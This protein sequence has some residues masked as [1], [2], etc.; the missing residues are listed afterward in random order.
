MKRIM[1][2]K[3]KDTSNFLDKIPAVR[4]GLSWETDDGQI[5][6]IQE[7]KG[8]YNRIAQ[9]IFHTPPKSRIHLDEMGSFIWK[10]IDGKQNIYEIGQHVH[11]HFQDSAEP[12]YQRL[13]QYFYTLEQVQYIHLNS[14]DKHTDLKPE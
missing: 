1:R 10:Q 13:C 11:T 7:N 5:I 12:L 9:K 6:I 2:K 4:R 3:K 14:P 8:F